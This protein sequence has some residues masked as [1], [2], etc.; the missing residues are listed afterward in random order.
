MR[1]FSKLILTFFILTLTLNVNAKMFKRV[2][3]TIE[4]TPKLNFNKNWTKI[5]KS[6]EESLKEL[7]KFLSTSKTGK[8]L[9]LKAQKKAASYGETISDII[10]PGNGSLTDTTLI[11]KFSP[12]RP[13]QV[14][15]ESRSV[16]YLNRHLNVLNAT[17]DLA[18]ELTHYAFRKPFNPY[19]LNFSL[20]KFVESTVEG[21]GGEVDAYLIECKVL[22]ELFPKDIHSQ[23]NCSKVVDPETGKL[24]RSLGKKE[25]YKMGA[26]Y[27][28]F[29]DKMSK[30]QG[31]LE[32]A[33]NENAL[34]ISSAYGLPYPMAA[35]QEYESIM[36]RVCENDKK[37][38]AL[39]KDRISRMP[40]S[41]SDLEQN[42][43]HRL[44]A[45]MSNSF[46]NRCSATLSQM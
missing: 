17:L 11:R 40:A 3:H 45:R 19:K 8:R 33:S 21:T 39:M 26:Y 37:R 10:K 24:S 4:S 43:Q 22:Q 16:V 38:L 14:V 25:F 46:K 36:S 5:S 9:L 31:D 27:K 15:L 7:V 30:Y 2:V 12:S 44:Y 42:D 41:E 28:E 23:T 1:L 32:D 18:H 20:P 35:V 6:E 29:R 34:F 13:D